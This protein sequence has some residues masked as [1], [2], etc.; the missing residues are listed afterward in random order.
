MRAASTP[1]VE[2]EPDCIQ[3]TACIPQEYGFQL[4]L[5]NAS[6]RSNNAQVRLRPRPAAVERISLAG[7]HAE[8]LAVNDEV[9]ELSMRPWEIATLR[10][11][12]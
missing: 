5:L 1:L 2:L 6:D 9:L 11:S 10:V 8:P 7:D 3:M 12:R 4:R